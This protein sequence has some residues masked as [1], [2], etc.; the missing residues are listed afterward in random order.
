MDHPK[1]R[2]DLRDY[3][4]TDEPPLT[5]DLQ[6]VLVAGRRSRRRRRLGGLLATVAAATAITLAITVLPDALTPSVMISPAA[7][8]GTPGKDWGP[9]RMQHNERSQ[10]T[11]L[12][13]S[14]PADHAL[15]RLNCV[16]REVLAPRLP[17]GATITR[18]K[19]DEGYKLPEG[20]GLELFP[21]KSAIPVDYQIRADVTDAKGT[22]WLFVRISLADKFETERM[23]DNCLAEGTEGRL[24]CEI[25]QGHR[26]ETILL[27]NG[28]SEGPG[29]LRYG[30]GVYHNG[31]V[32]EMFTSN[33]ALNRKHG[34]PISPGNPNRV[35]IPERPEP[36][37]TRDSLLAAATA[38]ELT[39]F[40][41]P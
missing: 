35:V 36:P 4:S 32:V 3:V 12:V 9:A 33:S 22:G 14:E 15:A 17:V 31:T 29:M 26:G 19:E 25:R 30:V 23:R 2:E 24:T 21:V 38:P 5:L 28:S 20:P 13:P 11:D 37:L 27:T 6:Q 34:G 40:P 16:L 7:R 1:L 39:L 8:C 10:Q 41:K 18:P